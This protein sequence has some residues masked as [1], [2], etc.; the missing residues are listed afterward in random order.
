MTGHREPRCAVLGAVPQYAANYVDLPPGATRVQFRGDQSVPLFDGAEGAPAGAWWSNRGDS[1]D[2][3]LTRRV[4][5]SSAGPRATLTFQTWYDLEDQFDFVYLSVSRDNGATWQILPGAHTVAD[6][7]TGNNYG[8]GWTGS[9]NGQWLG[10]SVD[11]SSYAGHDVLVRFEYLTDQSTNGQG[12]ALRDVAVPEIGLQ[13]SGAVDG[14]WQANGWVRVDAPVPERWN[15]PLV[16][17]MA[18]GARV[19]SFPLTD[20]AGGDS[21]ALDPEAQRRTLV[22]V[23]TA[24]RTLLSGNYAVSVLS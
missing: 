18:G 16:Q 8:V 22:I 19:E 2:S 1:L 12:F 7:A 10:E 24:P 21:L 23:P 6:G 20:P 14:G 9:S 4:D 3:Q 13:E 17:W 5:L 15:V 11:L